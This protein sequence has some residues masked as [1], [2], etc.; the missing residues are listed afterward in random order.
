MIEAIEST[1]HDSRSQ[2]DELTG[3]INQLHRVVNTGK[4]PRMVECEWTFNFIK[5]EK[6][7]VRQ[8]T[9][10]VISTEPLTDSERQLAISAD[11]ETREEVTAR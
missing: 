2:V 8:D 5:L 11:I 1:I 6:S 3:V 4:E 10:E 9:G 7:L